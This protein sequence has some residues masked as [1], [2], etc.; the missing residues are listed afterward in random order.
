MKTVL[1]YSVVNLEPLLKVYRVDSATLCPNGNRILL[2]NLTGAVYQWQRNAGSGYTNITN[3]INYSGVNTSA[4]NL[5]NI[6]S[7][8]YG[9]TYRCVVN[10]FNSNEFKL[11]FENRWTGAV[12]SSWE[13]P[14]NWSCGSVPDSNT[15]VIISNGA[16]VVSSNT[17]VRSLTVDPGVIFTIN[18]GYNLIILY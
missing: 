18:P 4:L 14:G 17:S 2:S 3:G 15:D 7:S 8:W 12:S 6:P 13:N 16:V 1:F 11:K 9:Y 5:L 10:N